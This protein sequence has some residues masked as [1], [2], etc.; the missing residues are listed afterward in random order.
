MKFLQRCLIVLAQ[1]VSTELKQ[2]SVLLAVLWAGAL[3]GLLCSFM[4]VLHW[5]VRECGGSAGSEPGSSLPGGQLRAP[6]Q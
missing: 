3:G 1:A 6:W 5:T 2:L 4:A